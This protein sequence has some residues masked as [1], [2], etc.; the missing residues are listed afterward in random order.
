MENQQCWHFTITF[1][2]N[3]TCKQKFKM[4]ENFPKIMH[5]HVNYRRNK[6]VIINYSIEYH[7][8]ADRS[9][10]PTAPHIHGVL[11]CTSLARCASELI[12]EYFSKKYGKTQFFLQE[13]TVSQDKWL[14]YCRKDVEKNNEQYPSIQHWNQVIYTSPSPKNFWEQPEFI[15]DEDN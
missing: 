11:Y 10:N 5:N 7:K 1:K 14:D 6:S 2:G 15:N 13:D 9:N 12:Y 3:F 8:R 4:I